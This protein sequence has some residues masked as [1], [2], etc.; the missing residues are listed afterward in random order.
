M[1]FLLFCVASIGFGQFVLAQSIPAPQVG[2]CPRY[3]TTISGSCVPYGSHQV[4]LN[5]NPAA[6]CP[7]GWASDGNY[8]VR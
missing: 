2:S 3:T 1:K 5:S 4:Y 8:C 7:P 6:G